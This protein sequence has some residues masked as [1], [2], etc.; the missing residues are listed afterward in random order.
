MFV[1]IMFF[2]SSY[3]TMHFPSRPVVL[4]QYMG[5]GLL[6]A[7]SA[8]CSLIPLVVPPYV[9]GLLAIGPIAIGSK[10]LVQT[11]K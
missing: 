5:I 7:I 2:S 10:R 8:L 6:I 11:I 9:I 4:G 1:L 3:S